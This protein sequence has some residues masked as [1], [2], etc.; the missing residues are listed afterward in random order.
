[1]PKSNV[2]SNGGEG[3]RHRASSGRWRRIKFALGN[4]RHGP[5]LHCRSGHHEYQEPTPI[6]GGILR[7]ACSRCGAVSLDLREAAEPAAPQ[8]FK[9]NSTVKTF[10]ILRRQTF[11]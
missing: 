1:M 7:H 5:Q 10:A 11:H 9:S 2:T 3:G 6:G 4:F 8:L